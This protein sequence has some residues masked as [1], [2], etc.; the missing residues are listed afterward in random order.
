MREG[1]F[2]R[3]FIWIH[4]D[5]DELMGFDVFLYGIFWRYI[6]NAMNC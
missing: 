4:R 3:F 1:T 2:V 6:G 5:G